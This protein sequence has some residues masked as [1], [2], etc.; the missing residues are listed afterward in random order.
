MKGWE[1]SGAASR[2]ALPRLRGRG[3]QR[4]MSMDAVSLSTLCI[5]PL[6]YSDRCRSLSRDVPESWS[7]L[8]LYTIE[9][10]TAKGLCARS[11]LVHHGLASEAALHGFAS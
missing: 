8:D 3:E 4:D 2:G 10:R 5:V 7:R 1:E 11:L 6:E 9:R